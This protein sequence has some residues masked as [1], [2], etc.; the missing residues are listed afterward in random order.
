M[1]IRSIRTRNGYCD[2]WGIAESPCLLTG[3]KAGQIYF[4][5]RAMPGLSLII[6]LDVIDGPFLFLIAFSY[7]AAVF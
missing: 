1:L 5:V 4:W 6:P 3:N 7:I 2:I